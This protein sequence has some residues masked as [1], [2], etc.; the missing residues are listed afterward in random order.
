MVQ[1]SWHVIPPAIKVDLTDRQ[2]HDLE[3]GLE[4]LRAIVLTCRRLGTILTRTTKKV[5]PH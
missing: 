1:C 3:V 2:A 5:E 4:V